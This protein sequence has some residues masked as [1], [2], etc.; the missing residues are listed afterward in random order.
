MG[1]W[2]GEERQSRQSEK[3]ELSR[4]IPQ[5]ESFGEMRASSSHLRDRSGHV[6]TDAHQR[7]AEGC[8]WG[9]GSLPFQLPCQETLGQRD[10][11]AGIWGRDFSG[12]GEGRTLLGQVLGTGNAA[13]AWD[14]YQ[15]SEL[16]WCLPSPPQLKLGALLS[17]PSIP[18][19]P[20][21]P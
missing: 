15:H 16:G 8:S 1:Q 18:P 19:R 20:L 12:R 9:A 17:A 7:L 6:L 21:F 5:Q 10:A 4:S 11:E 14:P 3:G 13:S 2:G